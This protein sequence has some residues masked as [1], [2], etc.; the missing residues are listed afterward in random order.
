MSALAGLRVL[1][2]GEGIA[3]AFAARLLGDHGADVVKL[4]ESAFTAS[5]D[6]PLFQYLHWNKRFVEPGVAPE[7]ERLIT[8]ADVVICSGIG[9]GE[10]LRELNQRAVLTLIS[11]FGQTGPYRDYAATDLVL[12]A[13]SGLMAISGCSGREPLR[14]GLR[15]SY[16]LAGLN[17]AYATLAGVL[18]A[19]RTGAGV[20]IDLAIRDC[21]SSELVMNHALHV[22]TG[23]VQGPPPAANDPFDGHPT[24]TGDGFVSL[25]TS[26]RQ[27]PVEIAEL[28]NEPA[29]AELRF[30]T[31]DARA[32][33][34]SELRE[35]LDDRLS[36]ERALT[37][38]LQAS[39]R[40]LLSGAVQHADDL[41]SCPQL[42]HR[43]LF[44]TVPHRSA[45]GGALRLP[46]TLAQMS[47]TPSTM[48]APAP[49]QVAGA[50]TWIAPRG[51][52]ECGASTQPAGESSLAGDRSPVTKPLAGIR[53][54]DLSV[55]FAAPYM[56]ALLSDLGAEVIKIESPRRIDQTRTDWGGYFDNRPGSEPWNR[57]GT[58]Q[59]VNR[60]KRSFA[61]DLATD[62]GRELFAELVA[63]SDV[64]LE[65]LSRG[66]ADK[67]GVTYEQ[68]RAANPGLVMLSNTGYGATGP[69]SQFKAQGTTLE[70]TMGLMAVTGYEDGPPARAGQS[71]PDFIA[72]WAGLD[73]AAHSA[74][75]PRPDR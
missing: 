73:R 58:F 60:G 54:L 45:N 26:A 51:V 32:E 37:V 68:Y 2:L 53:V 39:Q 72:C 5:P 42:E 50:L 63:C 41:L 1:E 7:R 8:T 29:L 44:T 18:A 4:R 40:G 38:F 25:Q 28:L 59:A 36:G 43:G 75:A 27:G 46:L 23:V 48:R 55:I 65:N 31:A 52:D 69:W 71:V 12:Q 9:Q 20:T 17:A 13:M 34:G 3:G 74:R 35:I 22:F 19:R 10:P 14:H 15:T 64:V 57:S 6:D 11:P 61:V 67:L 16:Y 62:A 56:A 70:A 49:T 66:A 47:R 24:A 30:A 33:S 21:L